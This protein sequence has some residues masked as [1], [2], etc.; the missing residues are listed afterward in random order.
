MSSYYYALA[1]L[2]YLRFDAERIPSEGEFLDVARS[3]CSDR[4]FAVI[5]ASSLDPLGSESSH[6][7]VKRF[8]NW[9]TGLRNELVRQRAAE[10]ERDGQ[11]NIRRGENGDDYSARSGLADSV[12]ASIQAETP[13]R[14]DEML[15][16]LRW[17]YIEDLEV[18]HF[19]T[20][21]Q[22]LTYY[23]KL[24]ILLRRR[25]LTVERG[26]EAFA[27][28]YRAV[29]AHMQESQKLHGEQA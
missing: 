20:I 22:M 15:D 1:S 28:H 4:D 18:G 29:R 7:L 5:A 13:L 23:L 14:A 3:W 25:S 12:R 8:L 17:S 24:Q 10:L 16:E 9:E 11:E 19:F 27:D 6:P 26:R 21:E 2:P